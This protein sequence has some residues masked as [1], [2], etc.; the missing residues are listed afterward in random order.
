MLPPSTLLVLLLA[1]AVGLEWF[2]ERARIPRPVVLVCGGLLI[3]LLPDLPR[4]QYDPETVFD[5]FIPPLL[6]WAAFNGSVRDFRVNGLAI[7]LV[8]VVLVLATTAA[9]AWTV[10]V[11][12]PSIP[13]PAAVVLGAI[14]APPDVVVTMSML[15]G[16]T[17]PRPVTTILLGESLVNDA[18]SL[19]VFRIAIGAVVVGKFSWAQGAVELV[20]VTLGGAMVGLIVGWL[21]TAIRR[22]AGQTPVLQVM[23]GLLIPFAAYLPADAIHVSGVLAVVVAGLY[24][25]RMAPALSS[26]ETRLQ[27]R[28]IWEVIAFVLESLTFL[29]IGLDLPYARV[30]LGE[31]S[32]WQLLGYSCM[33]SAVIAVV[34]MASAF[35]TAYLSRWAKGS[36]GQQA[37]LA[38]RNVLFVGWAGL[39]GGDSLIVALTIPVAVTTGSPFP[40][41][42]LII[43]LTFGVVLISI[44]L[45]GVSLRFVAQM[46]G[47]RND[48][49]A[50]GEERNARYLVSQAG[51]SALDAVAAKLATDAVGT[52]AEGTVAQGAVVVEVITFLREAYASEP[53][54]SSLETRQLVPP[55]NL[56][57]ASAYQDLRSQMVRAERAEVIRL[58][59]EDV[60]NDEVM[61]RLL[62]SGDLEEI[63]LDTKSAAATHQ[64]AGFENRV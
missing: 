14:V 20:G 32:L 52:V 5:I 39:R 45:Q 10:H 36:A 34:R 8:G 51:L 54:S 9:V 37:P 25:G 24:L 12:I 63:L 56:A 2:A 18:A 1:A 28:N 40:D 38:W 6:F 59:D 49:S 47:L 15:R 35:P 23:M 46:L 64:E 22:R 11:V 21:I 41:R 30:A 3:A 57:W 16:L 13:W 4:W 19:V 53:V 7:S 62:R 27:A 60:I 43:V 31:Y 42:N 29:L 55:V 58:R 44:L 26:A 48:G 61:Q 17:L 33:L 50:D